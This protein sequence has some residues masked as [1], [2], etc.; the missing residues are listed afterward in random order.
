M[1]P[2]IAITLLGLTLS[3]SA[4][5]TQ[6]L[7]LK[8][9]DIEEIPHDKDRDECGVADLPCHTREEYKV[10]A[11][12]KTTN[13]VFACKTDYLSYFKSPTEMSY[14]PL[15]KPM[16]VCMVFFHVGDTVT[17]TAVRGGWAPD[18]GVKDDAVQP[19][20]IKSESEFSHRP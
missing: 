5:G 1:K 12:N 15:D 17:F 19:F 10:S 2:V 20:T 16:K 8:V 3:V 14:L 9:T 6:T 11:H 7:R 4:L 18:D 13:F